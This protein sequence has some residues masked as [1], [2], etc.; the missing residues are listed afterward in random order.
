LPVKLSLFEFE[1]LD[2]RNANTALWHGV[3][4]SWCG[5]AEAVAFM[6]LGNAGKIN[7]ALRVALGAKTVWPSFHP[8]YIH[9]ARSH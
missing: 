6:H 4:S 7:S 8:A 3:V 9:R 2:H 5:S 1:W